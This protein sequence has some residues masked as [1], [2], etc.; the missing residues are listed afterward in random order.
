MLE[1]VNVLKNKKII[2]LLCVQLILILIGVAG[3]FGETGVVVGQEDTQKLLDE[4]VALPAGAY[5]LRV[6]YDSAEDADGYFEPQSE[7]E[8]F[9]ALLSNRVF[10]FQGLHERDCSFF[11][12]ENVEHLRLDLNISGATQFYGAEIIAGT[13]GSRIYLFWL[14][15]VCIP[16]DLF[17]WL[18]MCHR[19]EPISTEKL[20]V[21]L[22]IPALALMAS[23]PM[24]VDYTFVGDDWIYHVERIEA[25]Y[26]AIVRGELP[27]RMSSFWNRGHGYASSFFYCDTFLVIPALLR[28]WGLDLTA[29]Y[30]IFL[31]AVNLASALTA[32]FSFKGCFRNRNIGLFGCA[33]YTLAPYRLHNVYVRAAAGEYTAMIFFPLLVWGFYRIYTEDPDKKG[34]LWNWVLPV[35]G[36]SGV[37]QSHVLSCEMTGFFVILLCLLLWKKTF[38]RKTFLVLSATVG[39]T[40]VINAWYLVPFLDMMVSDQYRFNGLSGNLIQNKG[41]YLAHVF[42]TLQSAGQ[43]IPFEANGMLEAVSL[44]MGTALLVCLALWV[45]VRNKWDKEDLTEQQ[46]NER[47]IGDVGFLMTVLAM[48]MSTNL[49][50]WD[51]LA[52][53]NKTVGVLIGTL[54]FPLRINAIATVLAVFT[55]CAMAVWI[56]RE[57]P[58]FLSGKT[59]LSLIVLTSMVFGAYHLND[60]LLTREAAVHLY[61]VQNMGNTSVAAGEY[62]PMR[63]DETHLIDHDPILSDGVIMESYEKDGLEVFMDVAAKGEA[64][65]ELPMLYYKGY[66]AEVY[67]TGEP[68]TV[69]RG[70][71][72]VR[73]LLPENFEGSVHV[74]YGGMWYWHVAEALSVTVGAAFLLWYVFGRRAHEKNR[75]HHSKGRQ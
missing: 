12:M 16:L 20:A 57:N 36:F 7:S 27:S 40:I 41:I 62:F 65:V 75:D 32:Y 4:G 2:I 46:K 61:S 51:F 72:D 54:Q 53:L 35:I 63:L 66:H 74:W 34:Y 38:R 58:W 13:E 70:R 8:K 23:L 45:L 24:M 26:T 28:L 33:L 48:W 55:A 6:Y 43:S 29:A 1:K 9:K 25:L 19:R 31:L 69:E 59:V 71:D 52:S 73:V 56:L 47:R 21:L 18:Y 64:W 50:P 17:I 11:L 3:L 67:G 10:L 30:R 37:I 49:F 22:G 5:T 14:L 44:G 68:L 60:M 42:Y 39:M 15:L